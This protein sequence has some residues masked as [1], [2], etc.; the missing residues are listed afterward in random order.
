MDLLTGWLL[1]LLDSR[2][3]NPGQCPRL[4]F[5]DGDGSS[6]EEAR[7]RT[8]AVAGDMRLLNGFCRTSLCSSPVSFKNN[9]TCLPRP[10]KTSVANTELEHPH[11]MS[12]IK[13]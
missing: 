11:S 8:L 1:L 7:G 2:S 4:V 3:P 9:V 13:M 5:S 6:L 12:S 10:L